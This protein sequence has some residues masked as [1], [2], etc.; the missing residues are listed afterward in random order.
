MQTLFETEHY[1]IY[2]N[3]G[4]T[5]LKNGVVN[6]I[7]TGQCNTLL[8]KLYGL[9]NEQAEEVIESVLPEIKVIDELDKTTYEVHG[10]RFIDTNI[11]QKIYRGELM[12]SYL[13]RVRKH[14]K[15]H[16]A[17]FKTLD[18][19]RKYRDE[20]KGFIQ[21]EPAD[22]LKKP[23]YIREQVEMCIGKCIKGSWV[24][25]RV[26]VY[27]NRHTYYKLTDTL[28]EARAYRDEIMSTVKKVRR[29][30]YEAV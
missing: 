11:Y 14:G 16:Q 18:E 12:P 19:S 22:K 2:R 28:E 13:V 6:Q 9:P 21:P 24:K 27:R 1:R 20:I 15:I 4:L 3:E 7:E 23:E 10:R 8:N 17:S 25:Y 30:S 29:K 26:R 5:Y